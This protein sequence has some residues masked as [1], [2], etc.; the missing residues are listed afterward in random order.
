MSIQN[1]T[2][3]TPQQVQYMNFVAN[4]CR[5]NGERISHE[6][7]ASKIGVTRKTLYTWQD[8]IPNFWDEVSRMRSKMYK[9]KIDRVYNAIYLQALKGDVPAA[10]LLLQQFGEL[11]PTPKADGADVPTNITLRLGN[12]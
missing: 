3:N 7:F 5:E 6:S 10:K 8:K 2:K 11:Q 12:G 1:Y 9:L 4:G